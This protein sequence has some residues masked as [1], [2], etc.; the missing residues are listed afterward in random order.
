MH[1]AV[2]NF[3]TSQ[4]KKAL[5]LEKAQKLGVNLSFVINCYLDEFIRDSHVRFGL[6]REQIPT[7]SLLDT[8][9]QSRDEVK[10]GEVSPVFN[11]T[12]D[13]IQWLAQS[14]P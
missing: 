14:D 9:K 4:Q 13:A 5:A 8:L 12:N 11:N 10:E 1:A 2:V 3:K 7:Q 6:V